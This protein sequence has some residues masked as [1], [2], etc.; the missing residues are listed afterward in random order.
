MIGRTRL[1]ILPLFL[2]IG[3]MGVAQCSI[4]LGNDTTIC[5]GGTATLLGPPGYANYNWSN[6][7]TTQNNTVGA[8]GNYTCTVSYPTGNLVTNGNFSAGNTG[9]TNQFPLDFNMQNE[10]SYNVGPNANWFHP[11]WNGT[12]NGNFLMINAG[13]AHSGWDAWCQTIPVC[14]NQTYTLVVRAASLA[15]QGAPLLNWVIDGVGQGMLMQTAAAQGTWTQFTNSWTSGPGQYSAS[16]CI[17]VSSSFGIGNDFALDDISISSTIVLS[18]QQQVFVTPLPAVNLG[19]DQLGCTGD[20]FL[21]NAFLPGATYTWQDGSTNPTFNVTAAGIYDVDVTLNG[22]T[23]NDAVQFWF[24]PYPALDLGND[25]TLCAGQTLPMNVFTLGATYQWQ[26]GSPAPSFTAVGPGTYD[27]DLTLNGCTAQD[28]IVVSYNPLPVVALGNDTALCVGEQMLLDA[29]AVGGTYAW[30]DGSAASTF[31]VGSAGVYDVDVTVNGCTTNDAITV[32]YTPL[33]TLELGNDTTVCPGEPVT[34]DATLPGATYLWNDGSTGPTLTTSTPGASSVTV[35]LNGC[36]SWDGAMLNNFNLQSVSLGND[37]VECAGT[38]VPI[39]VSIPGATYLWS[40]NAVSDSISVSTT[41][42]YWVEATLN[43]CS[44][45]DSI[46]VTFTPLPVFSL[47]NDTVVCPG[48][49]VLLDAALPGASYLWSDNSFGPTLNAGPGVWSVFVSVNGCGSADAI[50]I[51]TLQPPTVALGNDTTLCPG[52]SLILDATL[53]GAGYLWQDNSTASTFVVN[54]A[55]SFSVLVTDANGCTANDALTVAYANPQPVFLGNDTT[56]CGGAQLTLDATTPG[57]TYAWSTGPV[58]PSINVASAGTYSVIVAQGQCTVTDAITVSVAPNPNVSLPNDTA[59]CAGATILLNATTPGVTYAWQD[60]ST[61][62]TLLVSAAGTYTVT[63]TNA[64]GCTDSD[65]ITVSYALPGSI[66]LGNDTS[67]C[68]GGSMLLDATLPGSIYLWSTSATSATL[69]VNASGTYWVQATQ[70]ACSVMDTIVVVVNANP[71]VVLPNDTTL[72][73]GETL[74]LDATTPGVTCAWQDGSTA[75]TFLVNNAGAYT[76]TVANGTGCTNSDAITVNY[77]VG[78]SIDLGND[79]SFCAGGSALLDAT[80]PGSFYLWSTGATSATLVVNASGTYWVQATQAACSVTD[81]IVVVVNANPNVVLPNDTTL[82]PGETLLL[83]ATTPGVTYAWQDGS[84]APTFLVNN[85]GAYTVTVTNG[86][87]CSDSDAITVN[88]AVGG[89][90]DLGNDTSFC[91]GGSALLDATLPG[92]FYL[93][94]T[95]ATSATLVVNASGTYWVQA[96]QAACSVTDTIVV[97]VNANPNVVLPNDTTLC[98]GE[99]LLLDATTPG[100]TYAWQDGSTAAIF[101]VSNGG[102]YTVTVANGTGCTVSDAITVNYA[103]PGSIDLGNDTSFCAG[104][105]VL[106]DASLAGST[107]LWSTGSTSATIT[108]NATGLYWVEALQGN[109]AVSDTIAIVVDTVPSVALPNDTTLC[110]GVALLLDATTPGVTYFWQDGSTGSTFPVNSSGTYSVIVTNASG[111]TDSDSIIV[112]YAA[113]GAINIGNDTTIC[114]GDSILLDATLPGASYLWS[115]GATSASI[116]IGF[117]GPYSVIAQIGA[118]AVYDTIQVLM[119]GVP[120]ITIGNDTTFCFPGSLGLTL[121]PQPDSYLW[122]DGSTG[123]MYLAGQTGLYWVEAMY[124]QCVFNDSINIVVEQPLPI[125]LGTDTAI[126]SGTSLLLDAT[127]PGATYLWN[128][129]ETTATLAADPPGAYVDVTLNGCT[130]NYEIGIAALATPTVDLGS[131]STLCNGSTITLSAAQ[132]GATYQWQDGST[133]GTYTTYTDVEAWVDVDLNGCAASDSVVIYFLS[134]AAVDLGPDI[135]LCQGA[136]ATLGNAWPGV[137]Y[138]WSTGSNA[139]TITVSSA[140]TYWLD[141]GIAGCMGSDTIIVAVVQVPQPNLGPD[142]TACTGDS[143]QLVVNPGAASVLWSDGSTATSNVVTTT[144]N[145]GV[146][147]ILNGCSASD[148][149]DVTFVSAIDSVSIGPDV[150]HC[151][152]EP[153]Q[154]DA[155]TSGATYNW[156]TGQVSPTITI[157][158]PGMYWVEVSGS[159]ISA[160]D[161]IV[162][163]PGDCGLFIYVPNTFTPDGDGFNETFAAVATGDFIEYSMIVFDRWGEAVWETSDPGAL[164]AGSYAGAAVP[165]GVYVW[166]IRYKAD[167]PGGIKQERLM[168][169]VTLLR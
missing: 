125:D 137:Q 165:D 39:G 52:Q 48:G 101:L 103:L 152:G 169:H 47:G 163:A 122:Q 113:T 50:T 45:R 126:C 24:N 144:G 51:G 93:W 72:C 66:N 29:T 130:W 110:G 117:T 128:T 44:V 70:A 133:G 61:A 159:C 65:A 55:G 74:L 153:L 102:A 19:L 21:L 132:P 107:Y 43:G 120:N 111:C 105:G 131:D 106:L 155:S 37:V 99:T 7:P 162:I 138:A 149:V 56:I 124:G 89:S 33:P 156:S 32:S 121:I 115:T 14:P 134:P 123:P 64:T 136:S 140:G 6:G 91:A 41:G 69:A 38:A 25:T 142:V 40:T 78:G 118:C 8:A 17:E 86:T 161:T 76:V 96:T 158:E 148:A 57:A 1:L 20:Q 114:Q 94:S 146:Q 168:G 31:N 22:C 54:A 15:T 63:V 53:P 9:F 151:Q 92:S 87:G 46:A 112:A 11:Q 79:T 2:C 18:D 83:D 160:A 42:T 60:A 77:A 141:A 157:T 166:T 71:N 100:V 62:A 147:L 85:A 5:Q 28:T 30:Q 49:S 26:N 23:A 81:T 164:W 27:V 75:A 13:W 167:T 3:H 108:A 143:V 73:P 12:G 36:S 16:F 80:L 145:V 104:G 4:T 90:I 109:C 68:A 154:L 58:T 67:F 95:G 10:P 82:C 35:T 119:T 34:W 135:S 59:L 116:M 129:G 127:W 150:E 88:Y 84:T 97:V 98:P 139:P